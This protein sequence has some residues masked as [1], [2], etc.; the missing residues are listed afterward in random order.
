MVGPPCLTE[1]TM[2]V[3]KKQPIHWCGGKPDKT[4]PMKLKRT[5]IGPAGQVVEMSL[6]TGKTIT[7]MLGNN[8][9]QLKILEKEARGWLWYDDFEDEAARDALIASRREVNDL[10]NQDYA[11]LFE[12]KLDRLADVLQANAAGLQRPTI[13]D[14]QLQ[15]AM[16]AEP[17]KKAAKKVS[18]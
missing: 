8:Y 12:T 9:A 11:K 1:S 2:N 15:N 13:T 10:R 6:A 14:E 5:A 17:P 4:N 7:S 3:S 18:K 16:L